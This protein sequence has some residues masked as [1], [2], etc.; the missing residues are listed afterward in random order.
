MPSNTVYLSI[1]FPFLSSLYI[2]HLPKTSEMLEVLFLKIAIGPFR[3]LVPKTPDTDFARTFCYT[4]K[5]VVRIHLGVGYK[6]N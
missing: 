1:L 3:R 2:S 5:N 6:N 4:N